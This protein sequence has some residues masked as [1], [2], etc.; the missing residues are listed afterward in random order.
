M[1]YLKIFTDFVEKIEELGD[2][3]RGRLFTAMLKYAATEET[4]E[5]KGNERFLWNTA[6]QEID[7]QS[8]VYERKTDGAAKA[9]EKLSDIRAN[10]NKNSDIRKK[11]LI[12]TQDKDKDKDKEKEKSIGGR[13]TRPTLSDVESYCKERGNSVDAQRFIDY[14]ESNGWRVG[15]NPMK[16][17]KAAVRTWERSSFNKPEETETEYQRYQR[18]LKDEANWSAW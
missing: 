12:S 13:M 3:E 16:D 6:K 15:K 1:K 5:L 2:A 8:E 14:Y 17:W 18:E 10:Q 9:R 7:R 4:P 11:S